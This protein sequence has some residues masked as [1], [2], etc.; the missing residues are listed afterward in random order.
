M[1]KILISIKK[2]YLAFSYKASVNNDTNMLINTNVISENELVFS[3]DYIEKNKKIVLCFIKELC[4]QYNIHIISFETNEMAKNLLELFSKNSFINTIYLF[5]E[6]NLPYYICELLIKNSYLKKINCY[7]VPTFMIELL[8]RYNIEVVSRN[9]ILFSSNFM[10][11]NNLNQFSKIFYKI[12]IRLDLPISN[13]DL[14]DF[15]TFCKIN[16]YLRTIHLQS[17]NVNDIEKIIEVLKENKN[18]K[19]KVLIHD[20]ITDEKTIINL[21]KL[22]K[23]S[24]KNKISFKLVYSDDY[25]KSNLLNQTLVSILKICGLI[26]SCLIITVV[27][28]ILYS[29]YQGMQK[30]AEIK[31]DIDKVIKDVDTNK[32]VDVINEENKDT[33]LTVSNDYIASLLTI[34]NDTVGWLKVNNTNIDYPVVQ[35]IDN[36]YYLTNNYYKEHDKAGWVF[37]D[38]RNN[39]KE[40]NKNTIFYAHNRYSSGIM[41]GTLSNTLNKDWYL[42][43]DNLLIEFNTLYSSMKWKVFSI[44]KVDV[45]TDYLKTTFIDNESWHNFIS[46]IKDRSIYNFEVEIKDEDKIITLSTCIGTNN[47]QRL[48]VHAVLTQ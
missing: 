18:N 42:N 15:K 5:E 26:T 8:D 45:T 28:Y 46:L 37:M 20:N 39:S 11:E 22:N 33:G 10:E 47:Q 23:R 38:Y 24:K 6:N 35:T 44:Y 3:D 43:A 48:V 7:N 4:E 17:V 19:I 30:V 9:E 14:E 41:F 29:N 1:K 31:D 36:D 27:G 21:K 13:N 16:K 34:N 40:L 2:N 25:L 12:S 32:I